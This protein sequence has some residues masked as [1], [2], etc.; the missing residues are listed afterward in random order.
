MQSH[1]FTSIV[2]L[3]IIVVCH[4]NSFS[5]KALLSLL[6]KTMHCLGDHKWNIKVTMWHCAKFSHQSLIRTSTISWSLDGK[7]DHDIKGNISCNTHFWLGSSFPEIM[8]SKSSPPH[9]SWQ[10]IALGCDKDDH[11]HH[12]FSLSLSL[13]LHLFLLTYW[14]ISHM[15]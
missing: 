4:Q 13:P 8:Q 9:P 7:S 15:E 11:A 3:I 5:W 12:Y 14:S 6:V 2:L 1:P 10:L